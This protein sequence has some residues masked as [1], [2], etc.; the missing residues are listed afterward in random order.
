MEHPKSLPVLSIAVGIHMLSK[1]SKDFFQNPTIGLIENI[2]HLECV[3]HVG[4]AFSS[5]QFHPWKTL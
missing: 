1:M 3:I 2:T 4:M 5:S